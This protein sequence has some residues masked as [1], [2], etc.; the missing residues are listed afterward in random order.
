MKI[1]QTKIPDVTK[2]SIDH[3][4]VVLADNIIQNVYPLFDEV[5]QGKV[6]HIN[7]MKKTLKEKKEIVKGKKEKL[8]QLMSD[9]NREK[10]VSKLL[11][12]IEKLV[13]SGLVYDGTL[14]SQ[15]IILLK[16]INKLS[17]DKLDHHLSETLQVIRKRF[18]RS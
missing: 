9:Y 17:N 11:T 7:E 5:Y 3:S 2:E 4:K 18:A 16:V 15:A 6:G 8:E 14:K 12:R 13:D 1:I 10:K